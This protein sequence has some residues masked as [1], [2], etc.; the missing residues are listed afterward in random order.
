M[1]IF[2]KLA[3]W[4]KD[5]LGDFGK[6]DLSLGN[7]SFGNN[8]FGNMDMGRPDTIGNDMSMSQGLPDVT[9][10]RGVG[11][12]QSQGEMNQTVRQQLGPDPMA[13]NQS[14]FPSTDYREMAPSV[15]SAPNQGSEIISAKL[16][17][18][19]ATLDAVNQRLANLER[20]A[21]SEHD[22]KRR[23]SW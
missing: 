18:I 1:S 12:K 21:F 17:A 20:V 14:S 13:N 2:G 22:N 3:F 7:N 19:K 16:D 15:A 5:R 6:D 23:D 10:Y 11:D 4:K 9:T 8:D